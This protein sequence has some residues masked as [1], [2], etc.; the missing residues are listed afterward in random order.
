MVRPIDLF[1][2]LAWKFQSG[3]LFLA[4]K[5]RI[6]TA[7]HR[8]F[9]DSTCTFHLFIVTGRDIINCLG[10]ALGGEKL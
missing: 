2:I 8:H 1:N 6:K 4:N 10:K 3:A 5:K 7:R 9:V